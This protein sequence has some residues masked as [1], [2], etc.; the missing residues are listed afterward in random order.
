MRLLPINLERGA[1][2][3][4]K[5]KKSPHALFV[6]VNSSANSMC[7]SSHRCWKKCRYFSNVCASGGIMENWV[8]KIPRGFFKLHELFGRFWNFPHTN[9]TSPRLKIPCGVMRDAPDGCQFH[10]AEAANK[11]RIAK[12]SSRLT[13]KG[14]SLLSRQ[15][16]TSIP[17]GIPVEIALANLL[18]PASG[19]DN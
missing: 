18:K 6:N 11:L 4:K 3:V 19:K 12:L 8:H 9:P 7:G 10:W 1:D 2:L 5:K 16:C 13:T 14:S 17:L 15:F